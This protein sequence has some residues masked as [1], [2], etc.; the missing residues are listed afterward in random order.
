MQNDPPSL[1]SH[2]G[3]SLRTTSEFRGSP[4]DSNM[5]TLEQC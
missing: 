5:N 4:S 3:V 1:P 2:H